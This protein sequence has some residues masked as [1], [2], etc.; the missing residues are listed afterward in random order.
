MSLV[1][2]TM[3]KPAVSLWNLYMNIEHGHSKKE[4]SGIFKA[5]FLLFDA[6]ICF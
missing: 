2:N 3:A 4:Q 5:W 6:K 1:Y